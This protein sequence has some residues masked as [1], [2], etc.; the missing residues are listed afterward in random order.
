MIE[1]IKHTYKKDVLRHLLLT[2]DE[3]GV[4]TFL[5]KLNLKD[6]VTW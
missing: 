6:V 1:K 5:K 4:I 3:E 2:K